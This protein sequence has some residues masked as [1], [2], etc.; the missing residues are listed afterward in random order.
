M[1][2]K[3]I[4]LRNDQTSMLYTYIH[5]SE[6]S[7]QKHIKRPV[8]IVCPGGAYLTSSIKEGEASATRF[9][10]MGYH[11][12][13]L[14]YLT[15]FKQRAKSAT[16]KP[17]LNP[18]SHYPEQLVDLMKTMKLL[19]EKEEEWGIDSKNIFVMGFSAGAHLAG[20]LA[21]DWDNEKLLARIEGATPQMMKPTGILMAY[22]MISA[23]LF[24]KRALS[25][26]PSSMHSLVP[27]MN[28]GLFGTSKVDK[29]MLDEVDLIKKVRFDMPPT[30]VW[31]TQEDHVTSP[32]ETLSFVSQ[33]LEKHVPCEFHLFME[34]DHGTALCDHT[35]ASQSSDINEHNA[36]W[37]KIAEKWLLGIR[38]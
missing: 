12:V 35:S 28:E 4:A 9:L 6:I 38:K 10:G 29:D 13:V 15:Y 17:L 30:F 8:I 22:P 26:F 27:Y 2:Y 23:N 37:T 31:H 32:S 21:T 25:D 24:H 19:H 3:E 33:L 14:R 34:G 1:I 7:F 16:D 11:V 5:D 20:C 18:A 36:V